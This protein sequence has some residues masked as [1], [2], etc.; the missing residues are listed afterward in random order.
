MKKKRHARTPFQGGRRS[1]F[2]P[3]RR[4]PL[5]RLRCSHASRS[6]QEANQ[7]KKLDLDTALSRYVRRTYSS[8]IAHQHLEA[9][10][11][12]GV[13]RRQALTG[14]VSSPSRGGG[15]GRLGA[16]EMRKVRATCVRAIAA[17]RRC[18]LR[19]RWV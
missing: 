5:L 7:D 1:T 16:D 19:L 14:S 12:V 9:F 2:A 15:G 8:Q 17:L 11:E 10:K 13:A 18:Q 4:H 3:H 6:P